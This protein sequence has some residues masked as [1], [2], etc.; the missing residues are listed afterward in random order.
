MLMNKND[1]HPEIA[2][3]LATPTD[4]N[5]KGTAAIAQAINPLIA[6]AFALYVKTKNYHW[7]MSGSHYRD[8]HLLLDEQANQILAMIDVLAERVRKIGSTTLHSISHISQLQQIKDDNNDYVPPKDMLGNLLNDNKAYAAR[9]R[10]AHGICD[11]YEDIATAS[12][13]EVFV[14]ETEKRTWFLYETLAAT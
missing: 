3:P 9:I 1:P 10:Q 11:Q 5:P 7:H 13:L 2:S 12:F 8:Y 4:L 14:D 6:D